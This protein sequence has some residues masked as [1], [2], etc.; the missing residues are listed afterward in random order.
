MSNKHKNNSNSNSNNNNNNNKTTNCQYCNTNPRSGES[1]AANPELLHLKLP[2]RVHVTGGV[3]F[4]TCAV[5]NITS[6]AHIVSQ[7]AAKH[8]APARNHS[9]SCNAQMRGGKAACSSV[10]GCNMFYNRILVHTRPNK[11]KGG[12]DPPSKHGSLRQP[13]PTSHIC[14]RTTPFLEHLTR[15]LS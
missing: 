4:S 3:A 14:P 15:V 6:I 13:C 7:Y 9:E 8:T 5:R 12:R 1:F 11:K 10:C 2:V